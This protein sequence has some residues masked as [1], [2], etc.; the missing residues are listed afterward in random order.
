MILV[1]LKRLKRMMTEVENSLEMERGMVTGRGIGIGIGIG[2]ETEKETE[3]ERT[4]GIGEERGVG[5]GEEKGVETE[6]ETKTKIRRRRGIGTEKTETGIENDIEAATETAI[7]GIGT[8]GDPAIAEVEVDERMLHLLYIDQWSQSPLRF[9]SRPAWLQIW[10]ISHCAWY[11]ELI[12]QNDNLA[13]VLL[14]NTNYA[15]V[16]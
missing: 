12:F 10:D 8:T 4:V 14:K 7:G 13:Q 3:E 16:E 9:R 6:T 2:S 1:A 5:T 11:F 15:D